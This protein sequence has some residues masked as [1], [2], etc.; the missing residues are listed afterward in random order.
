MAAKTAAL[1]VSRKLAFSKTSIAAAVVPPLE[2]TFCLKT[3][4]GSSDSYKSADAPKRVCSTRDFASSFDNPT[5]H[6]ASIS[7]VSYTHLTLPT[8]A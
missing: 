7:A 4:A 6:P 8:K 1:I 3:S 5:S 2:V